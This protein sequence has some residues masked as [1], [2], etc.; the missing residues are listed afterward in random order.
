MHGVGKK[1]AF[2]ECRDGVLGGGRGVEGVGV[3]MVHAV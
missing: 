2:Y 1:T 3:G